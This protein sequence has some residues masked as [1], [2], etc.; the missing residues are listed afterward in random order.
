MA[1]RTLIA[2]FSRTIPTIRTR[3][4]PC[5]MPS[6]GSYPPS[7]IIL[8]FDPMA[9]PMA[10]STLFFLALSLAAAA[11]KKVVDLHLNDA[12]PQI[13]IEGEVTNTKG[14]YSVKISK[15]VNFSADNVYPPVMGAAVT[16]TDSTTGKSETLVP[17]ADSGTYL[18]QHLIGTPN[19]TYTLNVTVDGK[20]YTAT[21]RMPVP[22]FLD[23]VT[24]AL[25]FDFSNKQQIN[26]V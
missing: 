12:A 5:N 24:F 6:S 21:S 23:S 2:S 8:N 3:P 26:A 7:P 4:R 16:I 9:T 18:T 25:N 19:H 17:G 10:K 1:A 13:V 15:T 11:C 20:Q 22:V 14:P